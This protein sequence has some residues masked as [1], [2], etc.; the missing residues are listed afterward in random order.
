MTYS[1]T[2]AF[3]ICR[4]ERRESTTALEYPSNYT[5][6][7]P[8][9]LSTH[10]C[11]DLSQVVCARHE[12]QLIMYKQ[13]VTTCVSLAVLEKRSVLGCFIVSSCYTMRAVRI[14]A[15]SQSPARSQV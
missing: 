1:I 8:F 7:R 6:E 10:Y 5:L 12:H 3:I 4:A 9:L 14:W 2:R 13:I 15:R 11:Y